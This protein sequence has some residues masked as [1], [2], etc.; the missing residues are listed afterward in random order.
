M[1]TSPLAECNSHAHTRKL[2]E[3]PDMGRLADSAQSASQF[4]SGWPTNVNFCFSRS[5]P[6]AERRRRASWSVWRAEFAHIELPT[7]WPQTESSSEPNDALY[8]PAE[9]ARETCTSWP[10]GRS[11]DSGAQSRPPS[12]AKTAPEAVEQLREAAKLRGTELN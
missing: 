9:R 11:I 10:A 2:A 3:R 12:G 4:M 6:V 8:W 7:I 5:R 1:R